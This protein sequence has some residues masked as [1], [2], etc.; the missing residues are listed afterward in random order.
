MGADL[1]NGMEAMWPDKSHLNGYL[2]DH[3]PIKVL[4]QRTCGTRSCWAV[5]RGHVGPAATGLSPEAMWDP[6]LL[7]C[8]QSTCG[9]HG[10][11]AVPGGPVGPAAAGLSPEDLWD[12][13]LLGCP[14]RACGTRGCWAACPPTPRHHEEAEIRARPKNQQDIQNA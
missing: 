14:R 3:K 11:W 6:R 12:L 13:W 4:P 5:P 2:L 7:G 10:C 1:A 8:P 9:T